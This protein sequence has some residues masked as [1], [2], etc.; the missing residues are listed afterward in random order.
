MV[1]EIL[2]FYSIKAIGWVVYALIIMQLA[3]LSCKLFARISVRLKF[4]DGPSVAIY[5]TIYYV[6]YR[7]GGRK[8][9]LVRTDTHT[10]VHIEVVPT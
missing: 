7:G 6:L 3:G 10:E 8:F 5:I 9:Y 1:T 4:Q 2:I